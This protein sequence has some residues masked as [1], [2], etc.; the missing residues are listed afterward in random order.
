MARASLVNICWEGSPYSLLCFFCFSLCFSSNRFPKKIRVQNERF[1]F[2][3]LHFYLKKG[4]HIIY[5]KKLIYFSKTHLA[6]KVIYFS[7]THLLQKSHLLF[8]NSSTSKNSSTSEK[9]IY[10]KKLNYFSKIQL[11]Q[12]TY[13]I[14]QNLNF[15]FFKYL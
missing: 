1:L 12:K 15:T 9:L 8:E 3:S 7:K 2:S 11:L 10:F 6:E 5:F 4:C 13:L 14:H